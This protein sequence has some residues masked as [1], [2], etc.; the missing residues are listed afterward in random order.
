MS[1][2][3]PLQLNVT[4]NDLSINVKPLP[5]PQPANFSGGVGEFNITSSLP[6]QKFLSNQVAS[7]IYTVSGTGN[8]KYVKLPDL[9]ALYPPQLEVYSPT[10]DVKAEVGKSNVSGTAR[11]DYSFMPLEPG[12]YTIP[13]VDFCYFN[14]Q[15]GQYKTVTAKGY[16]INVGKGEGS[17]KSQTKGHL[18]FNPALMDH[19]SSLS[20]DHTPYVKKFGYWLFYIVPVLL[21]LGI[22]FYYRAYLKANA[23]LLAV[24][25]RR[26]NKMA[27]MRLRK[28]S[29]CM[30]KGD[31][32]HFYDEMLAALW[33]YVS[34]K[35]KMST[36][37]LTRENV[38]SKLEEKGI[39]E[40][41]VKQ[42]LSLIDECEFAKYAP[43]A[44][45]ADMSHVYDEGVAVIN[46]LEDAFKQQNT[47]GNE[48]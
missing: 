19:S 38:S 43:S 31:T 5:S 45:K 42:T 11:F 28:A 15:T 46:N 39:G 29:D 10:P 20:H 21:L 8:L 4:P 18:T 6:S 32:D 35:L 37:E 12:T 25:S 27:R 26:A 40:E 3:K 41:V 14:P 36:S 9:N 44:A 2:A 34:D 16:T 22:V 33:G 13:K 48:K 7:V 24:K 1:V 23:D 47:A 30:K 17:E